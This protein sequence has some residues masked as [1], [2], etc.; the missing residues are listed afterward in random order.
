MDARAQYNPRTVEEVFRDFKGRR[1]GLIKALTTGTLFSR[2]VFLIFLWPLCLVLGKR[3]KNKMRREFLD[4]V[5]N[6][7]SVSSKR[8]WL[9][10]NI[11]VFTKTKILQ[12]L[13]RTT[14]VLD[15]SHRYGSYVWFWE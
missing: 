5:F 13:F 9:A 14:L 11:F 12:L 3:R 15:F 7:V 1:A 6:A 4:F 10:I 8:D 2:L